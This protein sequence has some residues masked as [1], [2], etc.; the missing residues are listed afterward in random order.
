MVMNSIPCTLCTLLKC[1]QFG[2]SKILR[3]YRLWIKKETGGIEAKKKKL[4]PLID[5]PWRQEVAGSAI[6]RFCSSVWITLSELWHLILPTPV[7]DQTFSQT[8]TSFNLSLSTVDVQSWRSFVLTPDL[9]IVSK[10]LD[11]VDIWSIPLIVSKIFQFLWIEMNQCKLI[12]VSGNPG[13]KHRSVCQHH[14][15]NLPSKKVKRN[16]LTGFF[17]RLNQCCY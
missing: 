8:L 9:F 5:E 6:N 3:R 13:A 11:T 12:D 2:P 17:N 7:R 4:T 14:N 16:S 15:K 1:I 10:M